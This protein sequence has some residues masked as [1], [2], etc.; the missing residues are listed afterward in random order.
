MSDS[1]LPTHLVVSGLLRQI[2]AEGGN[3]VILA[4]GDRESGTYVLLLRDRAGTVKLVER[5]PSADFAFEWQVTQEETAEK[6][7]KIYEYCDRRSTQ[8]PDLWIVEAQVDDIER[9]VAQLRS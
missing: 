5:R 8:D 6:E 1:R 2:T 3:G 4:K 7:G 9:F